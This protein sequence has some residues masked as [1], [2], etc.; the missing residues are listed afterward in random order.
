MSDDTVLNERV[1]L[2]TGAA[3]R[4]GATIATTLHSYNFV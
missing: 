3:H 4:I 1:V 2:I